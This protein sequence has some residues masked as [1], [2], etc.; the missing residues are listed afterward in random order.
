MPVLVSLP[1]VTM[2]KVNARMDST[3]AMSPSAPT[4][5]A[6]RCDTVSSAGSTRR[7]SM[8]AVK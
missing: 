7:R 4:P 2:V 6:T 5:A 8:S 1:P 3:P